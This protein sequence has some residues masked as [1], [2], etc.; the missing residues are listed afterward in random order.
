M[1]FVVV[2]SAAMDVSTS[3]H[4]SVLQDAYHSFVNLVAHLPKRKGA[5]KGY[6]KDSSPRATKRSNTANAD[7]QDMFPREDQ[8][9]LEKSAK[10]TRMLHALLLR[11]S[12]FEV[13]V[14]TLEL[15]LSAYTSHIEKSATKSSTKEC[16][17]AQIAR[18]ARRRESDA[19]HHDVSTPKSPINE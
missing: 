12:M 7:P 3:T 6:T 19:A 10:R 5:R 17:G 15:N 8:Q 4:F 2:L 16:R 9:K 1:L 18:N 14:G 13:E 11:S